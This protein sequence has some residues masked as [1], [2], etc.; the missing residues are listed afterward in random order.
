MRIGLPL[1]ISSLLAMAF[2]LG[3]LLATS[4]SR[5][6][7]L[8]KGDCEAP[9]PVTD[10]G[11]CSFAGRKL[12]GI[13]LHGA[14]LSRVDFTSAVMAQCDMIGANLRGANLKWADLSGCKIRRADLTG[15]DL[16][17]TRLDFADIS[18]S[19]LRKAF[20][21]GTD[22][23]NVLA[24][25]VD[26]RGSHMKDILMENGSMRRADL[27]GVYML[28]G[29]ILSSDMRWSKLAHVEM[30]G[31]NAEEVNFS[32]ADLSNARLRGARLI[33][34][35]FVGANLDGADLENATFERTDFRGAVHV[36]DAVRARLSDRWRAD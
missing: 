5:A 1:R 35:S 4:E 16:F 10:L 31:A 2:A 28:R 8:P 27:T 23:N 21:F 33:H 20:L 34:A 14:E 26:F 29:A 25:D 17:H 7:R 15:A 3:M 18:G 13:D 6:Q 30:T 24:D 11:H 12:I 32:G 19:M 9:K 22:M 36:P